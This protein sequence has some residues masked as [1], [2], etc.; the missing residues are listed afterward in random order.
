MTTTEAQ[1]AGAL[2]PMTARYR[3]TRRVTWVGIA[4]NLILAGIKVVTGVLGQSQALVL[5]G[6]H[7]LS[8]LVTDAVVLLAARHAAREADADHPYGHGRIETAA[9]VIV[10][11]LLLATALVLGHD[12]VQSLGE[13]P[14]GAPGVLTLAVALASVGAKEWLFRYTR[15]VAR[16]LRSRLLEANAWHHRSDALS[17]IVVAAGIAGALSGF[18]ALDAIAAIVVALMVAKAGW[19]LIWHSLRELVDTGLDTA[20]LQDLRDE[21]GA[22][23]GVKHVHTLRSRSMGHS[24]LLDLHIQVGPRVSVSEGH[25]V[26]EAVRQRLMQRRPGLGDVMVH[27]DPEEDTDGGPSNALPLRTEI[28]ARLWRRW[29]GLAAMGRIE[30]VTLH[31]LGARVH[32]QVTLAPAPAG[33]DAAAEAEALRAATAADADVG[34]VSVVERIAPK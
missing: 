6:V 7:S 27:V 20:V 33:V 17:S 9:T 10:G 19:E 21:A 12:A 31:Y 30:N 25:R 23:D 26:G 29:T 28:I 3:D 1:S 2:A 22:V 16:A 8:D 4:A 14:A 5:D 11:V 15:A 34:A 18:L 32:V 24:V 13:P